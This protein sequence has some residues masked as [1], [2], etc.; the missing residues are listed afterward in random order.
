MRYVVNTEA[1]ITAIADAIRAQTGSSEEMTVAEMPTEIASISGG[2]VHTVNVNGNDCSFHDFDP[3][4]GGLGS[5]QASSSQASVFNEIIEY[6]A[7]GYQ[8][9]INLTYNNKTYDCFVF[10]IYNHEDDPYI[11]PEDAPNGRIGMPDGTYTN[12]TEGILILAA[13]NKFTPYSGHTYG[14]YEVRLMQ[15]GT[16]GSDIEYNGS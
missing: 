13:Y 3:T 14:E 9:V 8:V 10:D 2:G 7:A 6:F 1:S 4:N 12:I 16:Y 15:F 5:F 11:D